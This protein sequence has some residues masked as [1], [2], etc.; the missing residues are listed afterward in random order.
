MRSLTE[1][2]CTHAH[3]Q[4]TDKGLGTAVELERGMVVEPARGPGMGHVARWVEALAFVA[5]TSEEV[6]DKAF[7]S[8]ASAGEDTAS[9]FEASA[10]D[11]AWEGMA[12]ASVAWAFAFEA[13]ASDMAWEGRAFASEAWAFAFEASA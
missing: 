12:F 10:S 1:L 11:M 8:E 6:E 2:V 5:W 4:E 7:A 9:A 3:K 13:S